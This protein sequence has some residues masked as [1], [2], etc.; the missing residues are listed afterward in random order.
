MPQLSFTYVFFF[1]VIQGIAFIHHQFVIHLISLLNHFYELVYLILSSLPEP[2]RTLT[3]KN[4]ACNLHFIYHQVSLILFIII[5]NAEILISLDRNSA[6][7]LTLS[8][9]LVQLHNKDHFIPNIDVVNITQ[10][11]NM[12]S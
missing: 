2:S 6:C 1:F 7:P 9:L 5:A 3:N 11:S 8:M 10:L 4:Q 12:T